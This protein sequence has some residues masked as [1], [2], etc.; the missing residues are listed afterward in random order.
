[1]SL[2]KD[3][4][5]LLKAGVITPEVAIKIQNHYQNKG[6]KST[7]RILLAFGIL[8]A[9]LLGLGIILILAH[10]WD[11]LPKTIKVFLAFVPLVSSQL[12]AGFG[13]LKKSG[14]LVWRE[15]S[16]A[17]LF[18]SVG[19]CIALIGQIYNI[20][21]DADSFLLS[22]M[23]LCL[24]MIYVMQS[25]VTSLLFVAGITWYAAFVGY[26]SPSTSIPYLYW[27]L[28][29][30]TIPHYHHLIKVKPE[31][32]FTIFH[33]WLIPLSLVISLG[34][35][36]ENATMLMW[37]SYSS[38]FGLLFL[39]GG[40]DIFDRQKLINNGYK[41]L[42]LTGSTIILLILSFDW[43]WVDL[44]EKGLS[45]AD[46]VTTAEFWAVFIL[47]GAGISL[48][49]Q[50]KL[51]R[52]GELNPFDYVFLLFILIFILGLMLPFMVVLINLLVFSIGLQSSLKGARQNNL[53]L[54]NA[55]LLLI[56]VLAVC[57][58]FDSNISFVIR[59]LI[60]VGVGIGFFVGNYWI[61]IKRKNHEKQ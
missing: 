38:L 34:T 46:A 47:T 10:N 59:G 60:F 6:S 37:V 61:L 36:A 48:F 57:R 30:A 9:I 4:G 40:L 8:G 13:L 35:T 49:M 27:L 25:S 50:Q 55:G 22:W 53:A 17:F 1:M 19:A 26:F 52:M 32:N 41:I 18:F 7:G 54:L 29:F 45:L 39:I 42:G 33:H 3:I 2:Q 21:G 44:H 56:V 5:E 28:L 58:F 31:G 14:S 51:K 15:T 20:P 43:F 24:P 23:L 16:A 11:E 12:L